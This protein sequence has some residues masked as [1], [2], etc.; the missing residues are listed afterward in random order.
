[1]ASLTQIPGRYEKC[2][3]TPAA[4]GVKVASEPSPES[5]PSEQIPAFSDEQ[6]DLRRA[7]YEAA[8]AQRRLCGPRRNRFVEYELASEIFPVRHL[9]GD[10]ITWFEAEGDLL[11]AIGDIAGKGLMAGMWFTYLVGLIRR[12]MAALADPAAAVS[13]VDHDLALA[14][15]EVPLTTLFV[16]RLNLRRGELTY[17]N[18]GHPAALLVH[19]GEIAELGVGG[20]VLGVISDASY[21][22]GHALVSAGDTLVAYSDGILESRNEQG[23]EFGTE[24]LLEA[25]RRTSG[26]KPDS[27]LFSLLAT[28]E[29][30]LGSQHREDDLALLVVQRFKDSNTYA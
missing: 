21:M 12:H 16:G 2:N 25:V 28:L 4:R 1:V 22:N 3:W 18:A 11:F 20:P 9:S 7:I 23:V 5:F 19:E 6:E 30:F 26:A 14:G 24:A 29:A 15:M 17:S 27:M 8:Q 13:A 10:F